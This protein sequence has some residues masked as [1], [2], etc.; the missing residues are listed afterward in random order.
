MRR[1]QFS[2]VIDIV[3]QKMNERKIEL[4]E[5]NQKRKSTVAILG[6]ALISITSREKK[7]VVLL[8]SML[9]AKIIYNHHI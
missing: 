5:T 4:L 1:R 9:N 7:N 2:I 8:K 6:S 3:E